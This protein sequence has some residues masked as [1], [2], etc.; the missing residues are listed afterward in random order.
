[1]KRIQAELEVRF[2]TALD[3]TKSSNVKGKGRR[4][5]MGKQQYRSGDLQDPRSRTKRYLDVMVQA[6]S[7][8][9]GDCDGSGSSNGVAKERVIWEQPPFVVLALKVEGRDADTDTEKEGGGGT[10][11][12]NSITASG[13]HVGER[14]THDEN[15]NEEAG[16]EDRDGERERRRGRGGRTESGA[17][18]WGVG[19]VVLGYFR[20]ETFSKM[21]VSVAVG[22]RLRL[23]D[24]VLLPGQ[25]TP[26]LASRDRDNLS[27][28]GTRAGL[29]ILLC[30]SLCEA[31]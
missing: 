10:F 11:H 3:T 24:T 16:E 17:G 19:G 9:M 28:S 1:M 20:P 12:S 13:V 29:P 2:Q 5:Y 7:R 14:S 21:S 4:G 26:P 6:H 23:Y 31:L 8:S 18:T 22:Q 25:P 15:E 27:S 30:T